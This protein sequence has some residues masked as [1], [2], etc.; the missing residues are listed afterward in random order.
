MTHESMKEQR[1][2]R[3]R[4]AVIAGLASAVLAMVMTVA[5]AGPS[6]AQTPPPPPPAP[7]SGSQAHPQQPPGF[8]DPGIRLWEQIG[9]PN[10]GDP[11][12]NREWWLAGSIVTPQRRHVNEYL[13]TG[14]QYQ[15]RNGWLRSFMD[16][17]H[18]GPSSVHRGGFFQE[19]N[20]TVYHVHAN[21]NLP[22]RDGNRIVRNVR[23]GDVWWTD[24]H[25][26]SFHYMGRH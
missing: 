8:M 6:V 3:G 12:G 5:L 14:G 7:V 2:W 9:W 26:A 16:A 24:D 17:G 4:R 20:T 22:R 23:T 15:D 18:A 19:Y 10:A 25:Y 21:A 11:Q 1:D 13:F